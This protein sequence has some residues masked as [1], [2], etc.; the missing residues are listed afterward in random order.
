M[1]LKTKEDKKALL[2]EFEQLEHETHFNDVIRD[3]VDCLMLGTR[4]TEAVSNEK[5]LERKWGYS[6]KNDTC[7]GARHKRALAQLACF[8]KALRAP[9]NLVFREEMRG[10]ALFRRVQM[11]TESNW[12]P[13]SGNEEEFR[14]SGQFMKPS[15]TQSHTQRNRKML[16]LKESLQGNTHS[17]TNAL[18]KAKRTADSCESVYDSICMLLNQIKFPKDIVEPVLIKTREYDGLTVDAIMELISGEISTKAYIQSRIQFSELRKNLNT[19][20]TDITG[21]ACAICEKNGLYT[22]QCQ[23]SLPVVKKREII[24]RKR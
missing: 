12:P 24:V 8:A 13:F 14:S 9:H 4:L 5:R 17:S 7:S 15:C 22:W 18:Q 6:P 2:Q 19:D 20:D 11:L 21:Q 23:S 16:L 1:I 10:W 3:A